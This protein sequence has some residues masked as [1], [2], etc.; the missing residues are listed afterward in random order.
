VGH[1]PLTGGDQHGQRPQTTLTGQV[2]LRCQAAART[3]QRLVGAVLSG[4]G[5]LAVL[6]RRLLAWAGGVLMSTAHSGVHTHHGPVDPAVS[7]G[8]TF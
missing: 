1:H 7:V 8:I 5:A 3:A 6:L 4:P 2:N